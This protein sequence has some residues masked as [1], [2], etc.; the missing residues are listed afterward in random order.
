MKFRDTGFTSSC[1]KCYRQS[2]ISIGCCDEFCFLHRSKCVQPK[3]VETLCWL[4]PIEIK[5]QVKSGRIP[6]EQKQ[7]RAKLLLRVVEN[8]LHLEMERMLYFLGNK[9]YPAMEAIAQMVF[10]S[11]SDT[12]FEFLRRLREQS[13]QINLD[14]YKQTVALMENK[15]TLEDYNKSGDIYRAK[16]DIVFQDVFLSVFNIPTDYKTTIK[17]LVTLTENRIN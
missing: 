2:I 1:K 8:H 15:I 7:E 3:E 10:N 9:D 12:I 14:S 16:L 17:H 11:S 4:C 13:F 5:R 6:K